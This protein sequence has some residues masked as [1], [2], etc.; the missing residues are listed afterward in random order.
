M[1]SHSWT[2]GLFCAS[3]LVIPPAASVASPAAA[4]EVAEVN[5]KPVV[6]PALQEWS[7]GEGSLVLDR[8]T[9]IVVDADDAG[10]LQPV[11][12]QLVTDL[13]E[14]AGIKPTVVTGEPGAGD[15]RLS[16]AADAAVG[17]D[18]KVARAEGYMLD[19]ADHATI[20]G[21]TPKAVFW[22]TRS[23]LQALTGETT[24]SASIV[25]GRA[26]DWPNYAKRGFMLDVGRR[27]FEPS[28]VRDYVRYMSWYKYN[29]FQIHLNDNE[30][31]PAEG[32]WSQAYAA[33][34][35]R[36]DKEEFE[37][38]A[39][40]DGAF[41]RPMWDRLEG[42]AGNHFVQVVPEIDAPAHARAFI[43]FDPELGLNGGNSDHLDLTKPETTDFMKSIYD[44]FVPWFRSPVVH[45]G[46]DEY[47]RAHAEEYRTY[48]NDIAA[49]LRSLGKQPM[50]WGSMKWMT[51][52]A[53]GYDRDV[54]LN[55]WSEDWYTPTMALEDGYRYV[56]TD[57]TH[58]YIV[59][60]AD[61]YHGK[62][63][64]N[65]PWLFDNWDP[66]VSRTE[67]V[68]PMVDGLEGAMS[69]VWNDLVHADYGS[70]EVHRLVAPTF[71][72]LAQK[73][74][75]GVEP[76][77][78]YDEFMEGVNSLGV[79]P[80]T[81]RLW[82]LPMPGNA[83]PSIPGDLAEGKEATQSSTAWGGTAE[84]AVDGITSGSWGDASITHT[85][86]NVHQPW[87]QVDLGAST[88]IGSVELYNR[89]DCCS[90]R[91]T[92]PVILLSDEPLPESLEEALATP[93]VVS[94]R[95]DGTVGESV[96]VRI[97]GNKRFVRVQLPGTGTL[98]LAEVIVRRS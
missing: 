31:N 20:Q 46:A 81:E 34:R 33:F 61:Y 89:T 98:S 15:I 50:A 72:L 97:S 55:T 77:Q 9:E 90:E 96:R 24:A 44:E 19:V 80:G 48:F 41:T 8:H 76:G 37:G 92:D 12:D 25:R 95:F 1:P 78:T 30:I 93:G 26:V 73:M 62:T 13:G 42:V 40:T 43:E 35:L 86:E 23:L 66:T 5:A 82:L 87:W 17:P 88:S 75:R 74:W 10:E 52:T 22:G 56:N 63:G 54:L 2:V 94:V 39:A 47:P 60:M 14:V 67:R 3:M 58:L 70:D 49:H 57:D 18:T 11:A 53:E 68:D 83:P 38:L 85:E 16:L 71:G 45:F 59:P 21:R 6:V 69:A 7:G 28:F 84:R 65:G 51:G 4:T 79:G 32:D 91:L 27:W 29:T 36:S 64:L